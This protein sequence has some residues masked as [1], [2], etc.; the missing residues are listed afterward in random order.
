MSSSVPSSEELFTLSRWIH[1]PPASGK[2]QQLTTGSRHGLPA[3]LK[4]SV[5]EQCD[6][7]LLWR[8]PI[9]Y[10]VLLTQ[11]GYQRRRRQQHEQVQDQQE[12][13][14]GH[15]EHRTEWEVLD[16]QQDEQKRQEQQQCQA[17]QTLCG[18][19]ADLQ[20]DFISSPSLQT[21]SMPS[22]TVTAPA[23]V[24]PNFGLPTAEAQIL[25]PQVDSPSARHPPQ[26]PTLYRRLRS[27]RQP[28]RRRR[29]DIREDSHLSGQ[30]QKEIFVGHDKICA[31]YPPP[32]NSVQGFL[33]GLFLQ[34]LAPC[35]P[36]APLL[37]PLIQIG[38]DSLRDSDQLP[39]PASPARLY[40]VYGPHTTTC[41]LDIAKAKPIMSAGQAQP[42]EGSFTQ[43][44]V[45]HHTVAAT[46]T[47]ALH[48][49]PKASAFANQEEGGQLDEMCEMQEELPPYDSVSAERFVMDLNDGH[50][51]N[52]SDMMQWLSDQGS[53]SSDRQCPT[54]GAYDDFILFPSSSSCSSEQDSS[55][56]S[57]FTDDLSH[58]AQCTDTLSTHPWMDPSALSSLSL[59]KRGCC[60]DSGQDQN[61]SFVNVATWLCDVEEDLGCKSLQDTFLH[62][63]MPSTDANKQKHASVEK[64]A[65]E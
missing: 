10:E 54:L 16:E 51:C 38:P 23:P 19:L 47:G 31:W 55:V 46:I 26:R 14:Q 24:L 6:E 52:W 41:G 40:T 11:E 34:S 15:Q 2:E 39:P 1:C 25:E 35:P 5:E 62:G 13:Q 18:P 45:L 53:G 58:S 64:L 21:S 8:H 63:E 29:D 48:S 56:V 57:C 36:W 44:Q 9:S 65:A 4:G 61:S 28:S 20:G 27:R 22:T 43:P 60:Q 17:T 42:F 30:G 59:M 32:T 49:E 3:Y 50:G 33:P 12:E 7:K 37:F